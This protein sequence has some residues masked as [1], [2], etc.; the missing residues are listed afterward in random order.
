LPDLDLRVSDAGRIIRAGGALAAKAAAAALDCRNDRRVN[1]LALSPSSFLP[2][3]R[4]GGEAR[5]AAPPDV[6]QAAAQ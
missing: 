3:C 2:F 4:L 5:S 1:M 6:R